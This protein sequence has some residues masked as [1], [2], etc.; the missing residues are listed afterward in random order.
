M[1]RF[2]VSKNNISDKRILIDGED[3]LHIS[4]VLRMREGDE[5][6]ICDGDK[7]DYLCKI[8]SISKKE[9]ICDIITRIENQ[10]ESDVLVTLYQGVPKGAKMDLIIQK[11]V[12]LGITEIVPVAAERSIV[13][14]KPGEFGGKR[15]RYQRVAY[16]AAKQCGRGIIPA[17]AEVTTFK[18][19]DMTRHDLIIIAYEDEKGTTLKSLLKANLKAKDIAIVIGPEGG[20]ERAEVDVLTQ[21]GGTAVTLG[22]RILR[23][24]TAGM[25]ALAMI[26]YEIEE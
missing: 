16:E 2:F 13:K 20:L 18:S 6:T 3:V 25:A 26:L 15:T 11:C 10:N 4:R 7:T 17:I 14:I 1:S 21:K 23:T 8:S 9:V 24:E 5:L 22:P 12:E 19:A